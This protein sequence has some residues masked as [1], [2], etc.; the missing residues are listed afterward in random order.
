M[1]LYTSYRYGF[2]AFFMVVAAAVGNF[3][4]SGLFGFGRSGPCSTIADCPHYIDHNNGT[5]TNAT[6]YICYH[7]GGGNGPNGSASDGGHIDSSLGW[8][9]SDGVAADAELDVEPLFGPNISNATGVCRMKTDTLDIPT[10]MLGKSSCSTLAHSVKTRW[11]KSLCADATLVCAMFAT[12]YPTGWK[13][14]AQIDHYCC[15]NCCGLFHEQL[16]LQ[17]CLDTRYISSRC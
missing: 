6:R 11:H 3:T 17:I 8:A 10:A 1:M 7:G 14:I 15:Q 16:Y 2:G 12:A 5:N 13:T 9:S 4:H